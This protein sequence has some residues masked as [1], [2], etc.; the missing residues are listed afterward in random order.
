MMVIVDQFSK[1]THFNPCKK[2]SD[3]T[4]MVQLFF[5]EI[6]MLHRLP[7]SIVS[8]RDVKFTGHFWCTLQKKMDTQ[9]GFSYAYHPQTDGQREVVNRSL[10]NLLRSLIREDSWMWDQVLA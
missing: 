3:A 2:T 6:V 4:H 1:M 5:T 8:N 10:G 7:K 9:L